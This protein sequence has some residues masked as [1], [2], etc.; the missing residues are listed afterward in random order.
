MLVEYDSFSKLKQYLND[1]ITEL[2]KFGCEKIFLVKHSEK[3]EQ[4]RAT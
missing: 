4:K 1:Q 2:E 3:E